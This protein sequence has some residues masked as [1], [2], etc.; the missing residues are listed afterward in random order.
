[1]GGVDRRTFIAAGGAAAVAAAAPGQAAAAPAQV[2]AAKRRKRPKPPLGSGG[3]PMSPEQLAGLA[4]ELGRGHPVLFLDLA[5]LDQN[6]R[7][8]VG[9]ASAQGWGVRPA[10][11]SFR[12]PALISYLLNRL[13]QPRGL[14]FGLREVDPI[15]AQAPRNTDL[16]TGYPPTFGELADFLATK[17]PKGQRAHRLRILVDSVPLMEH[18]GKLARTSRRRLP[19]EVALELDVGMGRGGVNDRDELA[20]C[21]DVLR[22]ERDRLRLTAVL[23]Y[24]GH[25]TLRGDAEYRRLVAAQA[26]DSYRTHLANLSELGAGLYDEATLIRNGPGSSNYRNWPG[27]PANEVGCGSAFLYAGYLNGGYDTEGLAPA[28]AMAGA[29]RRITSDHPSAPVLGVAQPGASEMEIIVQ[30]VG[31]AAELVHPPGAREDEASGGGDALVVPKGSVAL[32]GYV[33]Y[34]PEQTEVGIQRFNEMVAV[35]DGRVLRS[36]PV[37]KRPGARNLAP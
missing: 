34:R 25:A 23:G 11:K 36:W 18:L 28:L 15:V 27:G 22:A 30:G 17:P 19:L 24:D 32:G 33:L 16:M 35:R 7:T 21:L 37:F 14:V 13:P 5:A 8:V 1:M 9:F 2:A 20:A 12:S 3:T 29:V 10:L 31:T 6:L 26:Q 4:R